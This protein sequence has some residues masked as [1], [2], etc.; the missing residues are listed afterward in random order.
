MQIQRSTQC[1]RMKILRINSSMTVEKADQHTVRLM[2]QQVTLLDQQK[3]Y[4]Q[5][6][7]KEYQ[8]QMRLLDARLRILEAKY[9]SRANV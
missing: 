1:S 6:S 5:I 7:E 4:G 9:E 2:R 8:L 3:L